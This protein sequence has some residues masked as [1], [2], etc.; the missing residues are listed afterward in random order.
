MAIGKLAMPMPS[1]LFKMFLTTQTSAI[2]MILTAD[3][4]YTASFRCL[5]CKTVGE[6]SHQTYRKI[7]RLF[8]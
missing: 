1:N 2:F 8:I 3:F 6:S 4:D 5:I 7:E